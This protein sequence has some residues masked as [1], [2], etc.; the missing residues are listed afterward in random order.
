MSMLSYLYL[1]R[2]VRKAFEVLTG[3]VNKEQVYCPSSDRDTSLTLILSSCHEAR[4]SSI[5]LSRR[6]GKKNIYIYIRIYIK[7]IY[8]L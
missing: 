2:T 3:I 7:N 4:T 5:L 6:A 1:P 8:I